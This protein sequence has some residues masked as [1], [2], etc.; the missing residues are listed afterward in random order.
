MSANV[1]KWVNCM[2]QKTQPGLLFVNYHN[3]LDVLP[4]IP[5]EPDPDST[6]PISNT[7]DIDIPSDDESIDKDY[8]PNDND[9][10]SDASLTPS[11]NY[12][13]VF[14]DDSSNL[15]DEITW[16]DPANN[17]GDDILFCFMKPKLTLQEW[18]LQ[19]W[20]ELTP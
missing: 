11:D 5:P 20:M 1:I 14:D 8:D 15:N 6:I 16:V 4:T 9:D 2:A 13:I 10:A 19:E 3:V 12:S 17:S 7:V 18:T